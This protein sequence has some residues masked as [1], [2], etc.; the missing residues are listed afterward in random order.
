MVV[1]RA[2]FAGDRSE[3]AGAFGVVRGVDDD[4]RVAIETQIAAIGATNG[5]L[6]ANDDSLV[7]FAFLHGGVGRALLDVDGDDVADTSSVSDLTFFADHGSPAGSRVVGD[8]EN[9]TQLD[10]G[11]PPRRIEFWD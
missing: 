6:G 8:F 10:H 11:G 1:L 4:D 7:D 3:D 5:G 9:G 2:Q